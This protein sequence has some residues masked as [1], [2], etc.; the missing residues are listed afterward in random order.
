MTYE[1]LSLPICQNVR[2]TVSDFHAKVSALAESV[3][4]SQIHE[5]LYSL[6]SCGW[7]KNESLKYF[8]QKMLLDFLTT[9]GGQHSEQSSLQWQSWGILWNGKCL[10]ARILEYRNTDNVCSLSDIL[11]TEVDEKYF[12]SDHTVRRLLSYKDSEMVSEC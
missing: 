3:E 10:T 2:C 9:M 4:V 1:Q 12:L 11:E 8:S 5:A 6:K 7:L